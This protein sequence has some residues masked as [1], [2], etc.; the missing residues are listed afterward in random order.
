MEENI[1][2]KNL[3]KGHKK[4]FQTQQPDDFREDEAM[5]IDYGSQ[6]QFFKPNTK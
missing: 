5:I 1:P 4:P 2:A 6:A 3:L